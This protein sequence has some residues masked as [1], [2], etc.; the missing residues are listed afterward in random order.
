MN[1]EC[2]HFVE[3]MEG[4]TEVTQGAGGWTVSSNRLPFQVLSKEEA[5]SEQKTNGKGA[6]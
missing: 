6:S 3:I 5:D 4:A 1:S 2:I